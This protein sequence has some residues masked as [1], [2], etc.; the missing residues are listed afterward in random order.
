[1]TEIKKINGPRSVPKLNLEHYLRR[2]NE[3]NLRL[4]VKVLSQT[5]QI[6]NLEAS[7]QNNLFQLAVKTT[8]HI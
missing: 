5:Y 8:I 7:K 3:W 4:S 6:G 2:I 1:M